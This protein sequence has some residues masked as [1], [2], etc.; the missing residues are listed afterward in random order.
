MIMKK[1][2]LI[3]VVAI[4]AL[5][6]RAD[7]GKGAATLHFKSGEVMTGVI[8]SRTDDKV[9]IKVG[10]NVINQTGFFLSPSVGW[11]FA[12]N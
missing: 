8:T 6:A 2:L 10:A 12:T 4:V 5:T 7:G 9:E 1:L 3:F 11:H